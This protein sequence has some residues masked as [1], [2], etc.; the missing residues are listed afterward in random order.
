M[1]D[2][3]TVMENRLY[4]LLSSPLKEHYHCPEEQQRIH[5]NL[6]LLKEHLSPQEKKLLL[7]VVDDYT[8]TIEKISE[9]AFEDGFRLA[10]KIMFECLYLEGRF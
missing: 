5:N 10:A 9:A 1:S 2:I 6:G 8:L 4:Q 7:R 3:R